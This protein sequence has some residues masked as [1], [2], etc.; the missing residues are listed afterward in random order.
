MKTA[1]LLLEHN[2]PPGNTLKA[3]VDVRLLL[4][5]IKSGE[6]QIG[7]WVNVIGYVE[8]DQLEKHTKTDSPCVHVQALVLWSTGPLKL[9][10]YERSVDKRSSDQ[11]T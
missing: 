7:E 3:T 2:Y 8:K 6:T 9:Q 1:R 10:A 4:N 11:N 5:T